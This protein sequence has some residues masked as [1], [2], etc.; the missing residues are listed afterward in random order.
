MFEAQQA[1]KEGLQGYITK[2]ART[3]F[4][5][6]PMHNC[7]ARYLVRFCMHSAWH[8]YTSGKPCSRIYLI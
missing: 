4:R 1:P 6:P 2:N 3:S 8:T 7:S 5:A